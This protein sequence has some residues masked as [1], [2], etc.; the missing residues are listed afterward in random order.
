MNPSTDT[1]QRCRVCGCTDDDCSQCIARTG[2]PCH[3]VTGDLCSACFDGFNTLIR[4]KR[5]ETNIATVRVGGRT[6]RASCTSSAEEAC[7]RVAAKAAAAV[8]ASA[9]RV[10]RYQVLS[11]KA[12]RAGLFLE[13]GSNL[14]NQQ[15]D[16]RTP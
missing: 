11:L 10:E 1:V 4:V 3:W 9:W 14:S 12:A 8:R 7:N 5:G 2:S 15:P 13:F 6:H 16:E